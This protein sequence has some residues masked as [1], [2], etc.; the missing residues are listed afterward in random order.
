[1][2]AQL[3]NLSGLQGI[4]P[5]TELLPVGPGGVRV[6][7][8]PVVTGSRAR[9][10]VSEQ[11]LSVRRQGGWAEVNLPRVTSHEVVVFE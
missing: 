2:I 9:A 1:M 5:A 7:L 6:R 8:D 3:Q 11:R 10:L 4:P